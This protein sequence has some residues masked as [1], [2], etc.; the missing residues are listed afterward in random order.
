MNERLTRALGCACR[1]LV[2]MGWG[3]FPLRHRT[4]PARRAPVTRWARFGRRADLEHRSGHPVRRIGP[5]RSGY[6][7]AH[8]TDASPS[9]WMAASLR[10]MGS[11]SSRHDAVA[12]LGGRPHRGRMSRR[13]GRIR[14]AIVAPARTLLLAA[15]ID[16][17]IV[18]GLGGSGL[19]GAPA[20]L[21]ALPP[22]RARI[23]ALD[24]P[25]EVWLR[26]GPHALM[27]GRPYRS[28]HRCA[29]ST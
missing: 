7:P 26:Y 8:A 18:A 17:G 23:V 24:R 29:A 27:L 2:Q 14:T 12:A 20:R 21:D 10:R 4:P 19:P 25:D 16:R 13:I 5:M 15:E 28:R 1:T 11:M 6:D 22:H 9:T 3:D